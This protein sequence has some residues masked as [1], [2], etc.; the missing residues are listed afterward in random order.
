[1]TLKLEL[2]P[3][4]EARVRE[5]AAAAGQDIEAFVREV[6]QD[7]VA[8]SPT[9]L[10][11]VLATPAQRAAAFEAWV[12]SHAHRSGVV[13]DSRESIYEGRGE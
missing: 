1:M 8:A 3:A 10:P 5:L 9:P 11:Q 13:D 4:V 12:A 6:V 7:R 2:P